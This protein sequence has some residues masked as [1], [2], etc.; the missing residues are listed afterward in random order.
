MKKIIFFGIVL[1]LIGFT[2]WSNLT[3]QS[4]MPIK[5]LPARCFESIE[6]KR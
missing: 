5:D 3:C 1:S 6:I 2:I 4:Y